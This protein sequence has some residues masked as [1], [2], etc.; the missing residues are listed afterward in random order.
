MNDQISDQLIEELL[1]GYK[2]PEDLLGQEGILKQLTKRL[3]EKVMDAELTHTLGYKKHEQSAGEGK[4]SRNGHSIKTVKSNHGPLEL[5]IPRDRLN[6]HEPVLIARHERHFAGFDEAIINLYSRGLSVREIQGHIQD[7]YKVEVSPD[8]ISRVTDAVS[9]DVALWQSRPLEAVYPIVYLDAIVVKIREEGKVSNRAI[10]LAL[11]I[12]MEGQKEVLGMWSTQNEGSRYW[13]QV[14]TDL[15]NRGLKD[16]YICCCYGLSGFPEAIASAYPQTTVQLCIVHQIRNSMRFVSY[17]ERKVIAAD[18]KLIYQAP[19][20][21]AGL[22]SLD[23]FALK[24]DRHHAAISKSW[25]ANW[26]NLSPFFSYPEA[27]RKVIYTTNAIESLNSSFRKISRHRRLFPSTES[28]FKLFF[29]S[30]QNI[31]KKWTMPLKDWRSAL[32]YFAIEFAN[33]QSN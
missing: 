10:H 14:L 6:E 21:A 23:A 15:K 33:R 8:L 20:E 9:E 13:L 12:N 29:L 17:K 5:K 1:K 28:V 24:H 32:N 22:A 18:L 11:A 25:Q 19:T 3:L 16:I 26:V 2:T 30:L 7:L 4:N 27:L 31:E